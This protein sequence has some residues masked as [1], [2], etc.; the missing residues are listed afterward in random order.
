MYKI[1]KIY[2]PDNRQCSSVQYMETLFLNRDIRVS[3]LFTLRK[4]N[5][6]FAKMNKE[7]IIF[8]QKDIERLNKRR[9]RKF[10]MEIIGDLKSVKI[11]FHKAR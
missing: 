11:K 9:K 5:F 3:S 7:D 8:M 1:A 6:T 4:Y 2:V 10:E